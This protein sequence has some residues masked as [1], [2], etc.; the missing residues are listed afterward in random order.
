MFY[1]KKVK[2]WCGID[3]KK[4]HQYQQNKQ[5]ALSEHKK[6]NHPNF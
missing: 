6:M 5:T 4:I 1:E 3:G 2:Q